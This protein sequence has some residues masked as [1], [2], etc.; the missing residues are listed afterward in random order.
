M[1]PVLQSVCQKK[2]FF[3]FNVLLMDCG[4]GNFFPPLWC[5]NFDAQGSVFGLITENFA[6]NDRSGPWRQTKNSFRWEAVMACMQNCCKTGAVR[7]GGGGTAN[8]SYLRTGNGAG[9]CGEKAPPAAS[10]AGAGFQ[11]GQCPVS[12]GGQTVRCRPSASSVAARS[13]CSKDACLSASRC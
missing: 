10:A 11:P 1:P 5:E 6:N 3:Y 13:R 2:L 4:C 8:A 9:V 12:F 7:P